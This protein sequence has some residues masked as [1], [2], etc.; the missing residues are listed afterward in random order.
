MRFPSLIRS[1]CFGLLLLA[2]SLGTEAQDTP[3]T[4]SLLDDIP[5]SSLIYVSDYFSFVGQDHQGHVAFALDNNRGRDGEAY[6][7][8]HF[9]VL[10]DEGRGWMNLKG[11]GRYDNAGKELRTIPDSPFFRFKGSPRTGMTITSETNHLTLHIEPIPERT[12]TLHNGAATWMGSTSAVLVWNGRTIVGRVIYEYLM[13]PDFNRLTRTYWG[14]W[15][16]YQGLY[17]MADKSGDVYAHSQRSERIAPL[18]GFLAGFAAFT[19]M[20]ESM[21]D[22]KVE[23][24]DRTFAMGFYRWPTAWRITWNGPQGPALL[25]LSQSERK[26]IG[27]WAIGGFSMAIVQGELKYAGKKQPIYGLAELIM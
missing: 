17:L 2:C 6:Q 8:E 18:I 22:V 7:A 14:M 3:F 5:S 21:K 23:V 19:D 15:N 11:N 10:H 20:T 24:L 16:E 25:T 26:T 27:N 9:L 1:S 4:Q 13:M 12:R